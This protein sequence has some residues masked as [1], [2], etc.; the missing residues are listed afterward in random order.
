MLAIGGGAVFLRLRGD[1]LTLTLAEMEQEM[2]LWKQSPSQWLNLWKFTGAFVVAAGIVTGGVFFPPAFVALVLPVLYAL[3]Q[4][5]KVKTTMY[6]LTS[7]RLRTTSGVI[8]QHVDDFELYR[9]KDSQLFR[10]WWMRLTGLAAVKLLTSDRS[11]PELVIPAVRQ[12]MEMREM[13]RKQVEIIR[14][15][16]RVREVDF[17][18]GFTDDSAIG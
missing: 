7:E 4:F 17:D 9:V 16:K 11:T 13:L 14:D 1:R 12:G 3:W 18:D 5:L 15:R 8:N 2:T 6:E 10:P